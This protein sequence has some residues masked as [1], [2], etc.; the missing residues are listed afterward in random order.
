MTD[1]IDF[2]QTTGDYAYMSNLYL[3]PQTVDGVTYASNEHYYQ[4]QKANDVR[5]QIWIGFA[6]TPFAAMC[7][8]RAL[9]PWEIVEDWTEEHRIEIMLKGL[10]AKFQDPGLRERLLKTG[11]AIIH[12]NSPRDK[13]WGKKGRDLL[14]KLL[15][16]VRDEIREA[17]SSQTK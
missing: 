14:G 11:D 8:G 1:D 15:M 7:A 4:S 2:Y 5:M 16:Q 12:E 3:C 6:P 9:R 17:G 10:R 13:F